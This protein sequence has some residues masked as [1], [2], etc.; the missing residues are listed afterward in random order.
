MKGMFWNSRGLGD[1]AKYKHISDCVRDHALDFVA[2]SECSKRDFPTR[3]LDHFSCG[4]DY[5]WH[6]LPPSGRSGGILLGIHSTYLELLSTSKGEYHIK[7]HLRNKSD[8]FIWSLVA[9]YGA[10]QDEFKAAFLKELVNTCRENPHPMLLGG[11]F[12]ILRYQQ[13][14]NNDRFD[15]RWPFLFNAVI[16]SLDLRELSLSGRQFTWANNR[17]TPTF[18]KLDRVLV[19]TDWEFKYPL[20]SVRALERIEALSDHAPLLTDF[21]QAAPTS[22]RHQFKFELGW[23]TREGFP[24]LVKKVWQRPTRG[25]TPIQRW[26]NRIRALRQFLRGWAKHTAGIYKKE[27][28]RLSVLIDSLDKIAEVRLL[29][30]AEIEQKSHLNEQLARLLREEE[31]KWY[32][33]CKSDSLVLGDDNTKYFQMLAN[34]RHRKKRIFTLDQDEGRI[35]GDAPLKD[36]IT[37]YYKDLF[38]PSSETTLEMDES[39]CHDI[40]QVSAAENEFLTSAFTEEEIRTA[41]FQMKHNKSPGPDGFPAEFYQFFWDMLKSDLVQLF[42]ELHAHR[43]DISRLNFGEIIL[44]PKIKDANRIQQYRPICL[45]NVSFKIFTKVATNRL[46]GVADHVVKPTQTAFMQGRNI[47]DGVAVLHETVHELHRKKLNG[48]IFKIDFEKAYD[49]VKWPFLLQTLR[50]KGFSDTW[51]R[52]VENFV[53]G[54]SVAI[55]VNDDVGN[56]F[57]TRK[58][59]RQGDPASPILFNIVADMLVTLIERAKL[60]GQITGVIPHLVEGGLSIL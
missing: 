5:E 37:K 44:L 21:G 10:A 22:N 1:L 15:T 19:T 39:I 50:M 24:E 48:V 28:L 56:Y 53:S 7:F 35:E 4:K 54:G 2:I 6:I 52:W 47:L 3:D 55:K 38:G 42:N 30:A 11:D 16:D 26:N 60:A 34:G 8:N 51:C 57:Q 31:I 12:N 23:L 18:E 36:F 33:R 29:S 17:S 43:L 41:I 9:V 59:L 20:A 27:K 13:D 14:K 49:K 58:G 40:Q 46:N 32:Q 45:L 25:D